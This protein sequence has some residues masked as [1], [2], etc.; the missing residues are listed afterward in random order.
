M[1]NPIWFK[2]K[3]YG[4]GW[5]PSTWQGWLILLFF[6]VAIT[7]NFFRIQA[8]STDITDTLISFIPESIVMILLLIYICM[9][10]G[11]EAKWRWGDETKKK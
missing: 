6:I 7:G 11:E 9:L 8:Y 4:Y 3:K 2:A 10:T 5:T 1:K